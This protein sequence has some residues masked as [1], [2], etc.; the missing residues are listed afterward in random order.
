MQIIP[1]VLAY[2]FTEFER[3]VHRL[4][5]LFPFIQVDVMDGH[6]VETVSFPEVQKVNDVQTPLKYELH[7]MVEDPVAELRQWRSIEKVFRVVFPAEA[8]DPKRTIS[9]VR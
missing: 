8:Q 5:S 4:E 2:T 1:S 3:Q 7:L 6:F 9:F